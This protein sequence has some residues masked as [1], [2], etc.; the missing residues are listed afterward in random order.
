VFEPALAADGSLAGVFGWLVG[1]GSGAGIALM[2][3]CT[4]VLGTAMSLSGYLFPA[5]RQVEDELPD[6]D[7]GLEQAETRAEAQI[8]AEVEAIF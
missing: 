2:F 7:I 3:V 4:S 8:K 6:H 1:T 5:I